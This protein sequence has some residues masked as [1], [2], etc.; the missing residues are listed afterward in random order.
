M[1]RGSSRPRISCGA[2]MSK[3]SD[4]RLVTRVLRLFMQELRAI[5]KRRAPEHYTQFPN[6]PRPC[7]TCAFNPSTDKWQGWDTTANGLQKSIHANQPFYCHEGIPWRK[8]IAEWTAA[9]LQQFEEHKKMCAGFAA[10]VGDPQTKDAFVIAALKANGR[11][12]SVEAVRRADEALKA[13]NP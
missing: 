4:R 5:L 10:I 1:A 11:A 9:D 13:V 2:S 6:A 3:A 7:H 12:V 8:P